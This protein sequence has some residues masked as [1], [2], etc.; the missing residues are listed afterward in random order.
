[1]RKSPDPLNDVG[2]VD[3]A[4]SGVVH[5]TGAVA[6]LCGAYWLGPRRGRFDEATGEPQ[7]MPSH[8]R[9][10]A[11]PG[12]F[13]LWIGWYGFN[14]GTAFTFAY[15]AYAFAAGRIAVTTTIAAAS[16][17]STSMTIAYAKKPGEFDLSAIN[18][19]A[20]GGLV[21]VLLVALLLAPYSAF[22]IGIVGA[23]VYHFGS[24]LM[25]KCKIDDVVDAIAVHGFCG[26][27]GCMMASFQEM[28]N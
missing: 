14:C 26:I 22:V 1:M 20:L 17:A 16:C 24:W 5:L 25:L 18:N 3:F 2:V 23:F 4:G 8:F 13:F 19:G 21:S 6:A 7:E 15:S 11:G 9:H 12:T 28:R 27:W 10:Y